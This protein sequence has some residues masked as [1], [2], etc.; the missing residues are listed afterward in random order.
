M[1]DALSRA[2]RFAHDTRV[3]V[4]VQIPKGRL[5][6]DGAARALTDLADVVLARLFEVVRADMEKKHGRVGGAK[7]KARGRD[8]CVVALGKLGKKTGQ[9][10]YHYV[11]GKTVKR[12]AGE[13]RADMVESLIQPYLTEAQ[14]VLAGGIV[15]DADLI[16]AGLIFGT[17]L[18]PFRGRPLH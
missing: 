15:A 9:G 16:D 6:C 2:G 11:D 3:K 13:P 17:G 1:E 18:A 14:A 7:G 5:E 10:M 8:M 12:K 4:G